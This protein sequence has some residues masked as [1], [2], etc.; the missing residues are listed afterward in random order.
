VVSL[1][2]SPL[3]WLAVIAFVVG[4]ALV[5]AGTVASRRE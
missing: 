2:T 5:L 3:V 1:L 4:G